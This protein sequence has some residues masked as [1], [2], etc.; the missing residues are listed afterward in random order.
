MKT[1]M[2][3]FAALIAIVFLST[4][5]EAIGQDLEELG[6]FTY[7]GFTDAMSDQ[8][9]SRS[10]TESL[11]GSDMEFYIACFSGSS[12]LGIEHG[13]M[14]GDD[15]PYIDVMYRFDDEEPSRYENW[16]LGG[17]GKNSFRTITGR[18]SFVEKAIASKKVAL[19]VR[20]PHDGETVTGVFSLK[21]FAMS[22][23]RMSCID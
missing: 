18:E 10:F 9:N 20:D 2:S 12:V 4:S 15:T 8:K 6:D 13:Y 19:R 14:S 21:G 23:D 5:Y 16:G 1:R 22:I 17:N 3:T 7:V 11:N